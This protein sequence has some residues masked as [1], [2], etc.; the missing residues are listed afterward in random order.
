MEKPMQQRSVGKVDN[1][2]MSFR[3]L[4]ITRVIVMRSREE[5]GG[6]Q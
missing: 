5:I 1:M 2:G 6:N 3:Y 4:E